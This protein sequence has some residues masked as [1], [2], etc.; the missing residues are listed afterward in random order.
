MSSIKYKTEDGYISVPLNIIGS[1]VYLEDYDDGEVIPELVDDTA[2]LGIGIGTCSTSSGNDLEV[3]LSGYKL[4]KNGMIAVT[5]ENDVPA[6]ATLNV[7]GKG[8]KPIYN[9]GSAI[10]ADVIKAGK[11]VMFCYNG[12]Q[13]VVTS[14]GGGAGELVEYISINLVSDVSTPDPALVGATVVVTDDDNSET[15][16]STT[17]QGTTLECT[18]DVGIN[19]TITVGAVTNYDTPSS[20]SFKARAGYTRTE[21][22]E[23]INSTFVNLGLPSGTLW[24]TH[25]VGATNPEDY[26]LYFSWGNVDGHSRESGYLFTEATYNN[27]AGATLTGNIPVNSTYDAAQANMGADWR[28]PTVEESIE[29]WNNT[30]F[31]EITI[32]N[33]AVFKLT[34]TLNSNFIILPINGLIGTEGTVSSPN[35]LFYWLSGYKQ[36]SRCSNMFV[37]AARTPVPDRDETKYAGLNVRPVKV[38]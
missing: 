23:Y 29:L 10:E 13:Y 1:R 37:G 5:F 26:G 36:G 20:K 2:K 38:Q 25:N 22:F 31:E 27:S 21:T 30:T 11:T 6:N 15:I 19:Y 12:S 17:W 24:C 8:A 34:S 3:T 9:E 14:L 35:N 33:K 16:L 4:V 28:I 18:I 32:N 7:N